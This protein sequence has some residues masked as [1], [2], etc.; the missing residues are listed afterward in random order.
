LAKN[1]ALQAFVVHQIK[2]RFAV[3]SIEHVGSPLLSVSF[4]EA[5]KYTSP[6][7]SPISVAQA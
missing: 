2:A 3:L 1:G 5:Q 4:S 6:P 7:F